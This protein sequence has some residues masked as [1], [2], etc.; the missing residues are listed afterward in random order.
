MSSVYLVTIYGLFHIA[1]IKKGQTVLIHSASGGVGIAAIQLCQY[2]GA[3]V[4]P[5]FKTGLALDTNIHRYMQPSA[6]TT[7]VNS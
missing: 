7:S 5:N 3:T 1:Q 2:I 6:M 4:S